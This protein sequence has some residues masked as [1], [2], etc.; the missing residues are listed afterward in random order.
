MGVVVVVA[1]HS[2]HMVVMAFNEA[3]M[4]VFVLFGALDVPSPQQVQ[5]ICK[6]ITYYLTMSWTG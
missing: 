1:V 5:E 2:P 4:A 6:C 3:L